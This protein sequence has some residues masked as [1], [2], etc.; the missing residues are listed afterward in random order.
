MR[1]RLQHRADAESSGL[2][3]KSFGWS[4]R[5]APTEY[6]LQF[7]VDKGSAWWPG[8]LS[9]RANVAK[10]R[11]L[12]KVRTVRLVKVLSGRE[13]GAPETWAA[14][15]SKADFTSGNNVRGAVGRNL[16]DFCGPNGKSCSKPNRHEN[17]H[18]V[19][20]FASG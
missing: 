18:G 13:N 19:P 20:A 2:D 12:K 17:H 4:P 10:P 16:N 9:R 6:L 1:S 14:E 11:R 8:D 3:K 7:F 5:Q 15:A